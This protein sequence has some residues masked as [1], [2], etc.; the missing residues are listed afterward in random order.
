MDGHCTPIDARL[1]NS[2]R[3]PKSSRTPILHTAAAPTRRFVPSFSTRRSGGNADT[4]AATG[5][6]NRCWR[7]LTGA[8]STI[9]IST[10]P[11]A[12]LYAGGGSIPC[13]C[14]RRCGWRITEPTIL[15]TDCGRCVIRPSSQMTEEEYRLSGQR[16]YDFEAAWPL[17]RG[18]KLT[19]R[20]ARADG[21][22]RAVPVGEVTWRQTGGDWRQRPDAYGLWE[23]RHVRGGELRHLGRCGI[24]PDQ[25]GLSIEPGSDMREGHLVF[26]GTEA[27]MVAGH[28][29]EA[30]VEIRE[31]GDAVRVHAIA[32]ATAPDS[33]SSAGSGW[34]EAA[35]PTSSNT[36]WPHWLLRREAGL[37]CIAHRLQS[38]SWPEAPWLPLPE[39]RQNTLR[40]Q[41][42]MRA[43]W[44]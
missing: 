14:Q 35:T 22:S 4:M 6:G 12:M 40:G 38:R 34:E 1:R 41:C 32:A 29:E 17:F 43:S 27:V 2:P 9:P 11:Y 3:W 18:T 19:L 16:F 13:D 26:T 24:L 33:P 28:G 31:E 42:A 23:V 8:S 20:I 21:T 15:E 5:H 25:F 44:R 36:R 37:K 39:E 10:G 7:P 30:V